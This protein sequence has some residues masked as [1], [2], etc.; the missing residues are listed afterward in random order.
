VLGLAIAVS[1]VGVVP[2]AFWARLFFTA[3]LLVGGVLAA[4]L[5]GPRARLAA[6]LVALTLVTMQRA[7]N[8]PV[9][10][11]PSSQWSRPLAGPDQ[12]VRQ[13]IV[14]PTGRS[15]WDAV[16][17]RASQVAV[18]TCARGP[19]E[20]ADGLELVLNGSPLGTITEAH[21]TGP[22]PGPTFVGF[23][24]L[25]VPFTLAELQ[26]RERVELVLRRLP[27]A[28]SRPIP[29]CGTFSYRPTAGPDSSRYFDG[30]SWWSPGLTQQGRFVVELRVEDS[31]QR[32]LAAH[33]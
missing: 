5:A 2:P 14:L 33:Y 20:E 9:A 16:G 12:L 7:G 19:L 8:R 24:R 10:V 23:Y 15:G 28:T 21:A 6:A 30:T 11:P 18:Y 25:P 31:R 17:Q 13:E 3:V 4:G 22:R 32:I 1:L 29:I 27:Q 26:R